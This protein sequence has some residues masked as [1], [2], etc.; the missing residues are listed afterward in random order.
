MSALIVAWRFVRP[1]IR[2]LTGEAVSND[3][4]EEAGIDAVLTQN[5]ASRS[6]R[7]D[8]VAVTLERAG[9]GT[10]RATPIYAK[11][12]GIASLTRADALIVVPLD[13]A[14]LAAGT[15]VRAIPI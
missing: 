11:S 13:H 6:G 4:L 7:E 3:G 5:V 14:G 2:F 15:R 10:V 1:L 9:D 8:Y 12:S